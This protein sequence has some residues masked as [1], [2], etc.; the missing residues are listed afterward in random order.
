MKKAGIRV[1]AAIV[2]VV[3]MLGISGC[4]RK[5][6]PAERAGKQVDQTV[7]KGGEQ[8]EKAGENVQDTAEGKNNNR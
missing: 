8:L 1:V 7:E 5:E 4:P 6:G 3:L 2:M